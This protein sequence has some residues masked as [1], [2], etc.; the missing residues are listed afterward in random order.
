MVSVCELEPAVW[1]GFTVGGVVWIVTD[2]CPV[3]ILT[4][5]QS[6]FPALRMS[7]IPP[8]HPSFQPLTTTDLAG[9]LIWLVVF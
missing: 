8:V 1:V 3:S 4:V 5:S 2:T 7:H 9:S 6:S